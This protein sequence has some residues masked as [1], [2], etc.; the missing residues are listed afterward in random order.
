MS[1]R[2]NGIARMLTMYM[3][4]RRQRGIRMSHEMACRDMKIRYLKSYILKFSIWCRAGNKRGVPL[5]SL[6]SYKAAYP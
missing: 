6:K 4:A 1:T 2:M 3:R 5:K